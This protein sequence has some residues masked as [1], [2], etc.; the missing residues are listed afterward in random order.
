MDIGA[1]EELRIRTIGA[2]T[3]SVGVV[4]SLRRLLV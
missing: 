1:D 3:G 4:L 2:V